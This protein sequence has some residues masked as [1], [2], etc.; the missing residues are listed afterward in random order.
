MV[1][2]TA[3]ARSPK[4]FLDD[5][6]KEM[7]GEVWITLGGKCER[8]GVE[9]ICISYKYNSKK[10]LI[11]T[12]TLGAGST[13]KGKRYLAKFNNVYGNVCHCK[14]P[15]PAVLLRFFFGLQRCGRCKPDA[16]A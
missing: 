15:R 6:M 14:V 4:K 2:K 3:H 5:K 16:S 7:P 10:V 8:T 13:K 11:F 12:T 9:L 1:I